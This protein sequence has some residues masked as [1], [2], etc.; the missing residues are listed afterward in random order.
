LSQPIIIGIADVFVPIPLEKSVLPG[1][2]G[3]LVML[4]M[5]DSYLQ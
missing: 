3:V 2:G 4:V 5:S 1:Y